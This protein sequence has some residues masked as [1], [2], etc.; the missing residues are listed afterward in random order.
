MKVILLTISLLTSISLYAQEKSQTILSLDFGISSSKDVSFDDYYN[1]ERG[2]FAPSFGLNVYSQIKG[3]HWFTTGLNYYQIGD[4]Y[5][6]YTGRNYETTDVKIYVN[7]IKIPAFYSMFFDKGK[8]V[9]FLI[10]AGPSVD[11]I[12]GESI[13]KPKT[14]LNSPD[15][16]RDNVSQG[17]VGKRLFIPLNIAAGLSFKNK[18]GVVK[19]YLEV[20]LYGRAMNIYDDSTGSKSSYDNFSLKYGVFLTN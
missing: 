4:I 17:K 15:G 3:V 19:S 11:F 2:M 12:F 13:I 18:E 8:R 5:D 10:K 7:T 9:N 14:S 20:L 1:D 6:Y 16:F